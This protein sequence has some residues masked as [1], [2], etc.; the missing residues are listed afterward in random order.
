MGKVDFDLNQARFI[1]FLF[2]C[3]TT[4][5][6]AIKRTV[7]VGSSAIYD[8]FEN[9]INS[10]E[11]DSYDNY[12]QAVMHSRGIKPTDYRILNTIDIQ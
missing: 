1:T 6:V 8:A 10:F 2:P 11:A 9:I 12:I 5:T 4:R 7:R 3:N